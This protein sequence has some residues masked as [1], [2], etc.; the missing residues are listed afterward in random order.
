VIAGMVHLLAH[1]FFKALLFLGA[2]SVIQACHHEHDIRKMGGLQRVMPVTF[3]AY[4]IGMMSLSG[5]PLFFSG[6]WTKEEILHVTSHW[7]ASRVP[8]FLVLAGVVLTAL[9]MTRQLIY[10]F[11]GHPRASSQD[12][13]ESPAVMTIPLIVLVFCT[14]FLSFVLTPGW[15]WLHDYLGGRRPI[16]ELARLIQPTFWLSLALVATG[17]AIGVAIYRK[18]DQVDPIERS[19]PALF[20]FLE[21]RMWIDEVYERTVVALSAALAR[22][23]DWMDRNVWDAAVRAVGR[24]GQIFGIV[25]ADVDERGINAGVD[26]TMTGGRSFGRAMSG[27]HSG[28]IQT[29]LGAIAIGMVAL[30]LL[31]AWLG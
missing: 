9:Y 15:P 31:Y 10:I 2:G 6:A 27:W 25:T 11:F 29:Y 4:A 20:R 8:Y 1:G 28:Q 18:F 24:L 12:A 19:Q 13:R 21:N 17:I 3:R 14:I 16:L 5:V 23:S 22:F 30:L 7:A 26:Q